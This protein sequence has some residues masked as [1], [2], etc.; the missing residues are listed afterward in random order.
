MSK[1]KRVYAKPYS[2]KIR[3]K[4]RPYLNHAAVRGL[5]NPGP[6]SPAAPASDNRGLFPFLDQLGG[7]DGII[8][9]MGKVQKMMKMFQ[10]FGPMLNMFQSFGAMFG[11]KA[12]TSSTIPA[13]LT[14]HANK[15][16]P[17]H[18]RG[19]GKTK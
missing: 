12:T 14:A 1:R 16:N 18:R 3:S 5:L 8:A 17:Q 6:A 13:R 9:T 11:G 15:T 10:Q 4:P 7:I 2:P 19:A